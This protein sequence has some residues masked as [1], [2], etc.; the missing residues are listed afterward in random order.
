MR[1]FIIGAVGVVLMLAGCTAPQMG[2]AALNAA[3]QTIQAEDLAD[4]IRILS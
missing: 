2:D 1:L 3:L 4:D